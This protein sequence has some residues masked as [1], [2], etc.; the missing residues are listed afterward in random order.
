MS[1]LW[2]NFRRRWS[3]SSYELEA[4][5]ESGCLTCDLLMKAVI[6]FGPNFADVKRLHLRLSSLVPQ[7]RLTV[8]DCR[9]VADREFY[10]NHPHGV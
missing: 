7:L 1:R 8:E 9:D 6:A 10:L 3:I 4:F 2:R 5:A